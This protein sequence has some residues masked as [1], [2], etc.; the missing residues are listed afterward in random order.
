MPR[1]SYSAGY[2]S[3][4]IISLPDPAKP[5]DRRPVIPSSIGVY[6]VCPHCKATV[7][8]RK[9]TRTVGYNIIAPHAM[10]GARANVRMGRPHCPGSGTP[11]ENTELA[12][13]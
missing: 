10:G 3:G 6:V 5:V 11:A 8:V 7:P 4:R 12:D 1:R 13:R 9:G 2:K